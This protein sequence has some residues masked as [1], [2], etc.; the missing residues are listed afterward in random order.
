MAGRSE[1]RSRCALPRIAIG[2]R[3]IFKLI[4]PV[5]VLPFANCR[6]ILTSALDHGSRML[7]LYLGL[8]LRGPRRPIGEPGRRHAALRAVFAIA[9][10]SS[11]IAYTQRIDIKRLQT[12][13]GSAGTSPHEQRVPRMERS[14][15][16]R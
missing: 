12:T 4:T 8:A 9:W 3:P 10:S 15:M 5:G 11:M 7:R 16:R 14:G 2:V 1:I 6:N 13:N